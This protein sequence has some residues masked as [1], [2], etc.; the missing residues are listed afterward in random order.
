MEMLGRALKLYS[1][2]FNIALYLKSLFLIKIEQGASLDIETLQIYEN[3][4]GFAS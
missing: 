3:E 2:I 1:I 4:K